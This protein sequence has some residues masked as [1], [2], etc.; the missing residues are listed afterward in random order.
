[1]A[2]TYP[3]DRT[4]PDGK[5]CD[6][7]NELPAA[8]WMKS[9]NKWCCSRTTSGCPTMKAKL[10]ETKRLTKLLKEKYPLIDLNFVSARYP[11]AAS[12]DIK[13]GTLRWNKE[14]QVVEARCT[15]FEC[16]REW[17]VVPM[18]HIDLR[19][20]ALTPTNKNGGT[21]GGD[22]YKYYCDEK[23]RSLCFAHGKTGSMLYKEVVMRHMV[24]WEEDEEWYYDGQTE[25]A[26]VSQKNL[27]RETCMIRDEWTCVRC[28]APAEHVHH[29]HP[30]KTHPMEVVDPDNG[31]CVCRKCHYYHFHKGGEICSLPNLSK[32]VCFS[33][34]NGQ[35]KRPKTKSNIILSEGVLLFTFPHQVESD[36][37]KDSQRQLDIR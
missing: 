31:I 9:R 27:W 25:L 1:M 34:V 29:E 4:P 14:K 32:K 33:I 16:K 36:L 24:D 28:G 18:G 13:D 37:M 35:P 6:Y 12:V 8:Y 2:Y 10:K 3:V 17:Y 30:V 20:W 7:C 26:K 5:I 19:E 15:Y 22:G 23:C 11:L 21:K